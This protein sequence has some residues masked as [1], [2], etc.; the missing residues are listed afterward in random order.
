[1]S[2]VLDDNL[3]PTREELYD[4]LYLDYFVDKT[5]KAFPS[6]FSETTEFQILVR[7][8]AWAVARSYQQPRILKYYQNMVWR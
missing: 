6:I 3:N 1:M 7:L 8:M 2:F 4:D 5:K